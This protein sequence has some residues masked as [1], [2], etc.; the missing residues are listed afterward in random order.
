[1]PKTCLKY[2]KLPLKDDFLFFLNL[3]LALKE[4]FQKGGQKIFSSSRANSQK[5]RLFQGGARG[6]QNFSRPLE[7]SCIRAWTYMVPK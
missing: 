3:A 7:K 4:F 6:G 1:M 2:I 5:H